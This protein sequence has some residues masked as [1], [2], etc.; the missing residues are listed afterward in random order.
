MVTLYLAAV[1]C[2][3]VSIRYLI[4]RACRV[5]VKTAGDRGGNTHTKQTAR[6]RLRLH[7]PHHI[8]TT[9]TQNPT[10]THDFIS[11]V[12]GLPT[13]QFWEWGSCFRK[14]LLKW[15]SKIYFV[16]LKHP[17]GNYDCTK[18][19][20]FVTDSSF[21]IRGFAILVIEIETIMKYL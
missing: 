12:P 8:T 13:V 14:Y 10:C 4:K 2:Q 15:P 11:L 20:F 3:I 7:H 19:F 21:R 6:H 5:T 18:W 17:R 1:R 16:K 9:S